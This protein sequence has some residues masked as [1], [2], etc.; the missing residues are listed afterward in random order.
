MFDLDVWT[1]HRCIKSTGTVVIKD[2]GHHV[3]CIKSKSPRRKV[4]TLDHRATSLPKDYLVN[5]FP[6]GRTSWF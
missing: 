6:I 2:F 5:H 1:P 4:N 3:W